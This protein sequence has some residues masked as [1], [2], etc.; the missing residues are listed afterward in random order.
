ME[1][2]LDKG[3]FRILGRRL[4]TRTLEHMA[5]KKEKSKMCNA[6]SVFY[7]IVAFET[8]NAGQVLYLLMRREVQMI[9]DF[10]L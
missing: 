3:R 6:K 1:V 4:R 2:A 9:E 5:R 10:T 7:N 8:E